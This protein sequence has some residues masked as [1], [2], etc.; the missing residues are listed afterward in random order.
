MNDNLSD[1][2]SCTNI[3]IEQ[4]ILLHLDIKISFIQI[5]Q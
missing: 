5:S 1:D 4:K 3:F 2:E